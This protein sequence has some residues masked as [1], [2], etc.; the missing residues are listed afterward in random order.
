M[1]DSNP[2]E[3]TVDPHGNPISQEDG[4]PEPDPKYIG[5]YRVE[6]RLGKGGF[7][8]VFLAYDEHLERNVA[9][10]V[11]HAILISGPDDAEGYLEEAR[12]VASLDHAA[13]VPV[14]DVGSTPEC[15]FYIVSKYIEGTNLRTHLKQHRY[16]YGEAAE[17]IATVAEA[18]H[19]AHKQGLVHRD[20]KPGNILIDGQGTPHVV[21]FGLALREQNIGKG[22]KCAGTPAY[23][24]P[25][26]A[27]GE[28]HRVDGRSDIFSLGVVF[29]QLLA[30][31]KPFRGD[32]QTEILERV[33]R[34]EP[35]PLRQYDEKMPKELERICHKALAKRASERYSSAHDLAEDLRIFLA[36]DTAIPSAT[37]ASQF[38]PLESDTNSS[39]KTTS[40]TSG[41]STSQSIA[42]VSV[43][44]SEPIKVVPRGLRSF[45]AHDADFFLELL[46]GPRDRSGL[47]D[48][49]QFW[50]TRIEES[51]PDDTF[52][53]GL[54][55]G[56]SG[57]G[58]SSLVK[59]GLLPRLSE[60][61]M[62]VYIESTPAD[63][64]TRV[65]RGI[66]KACPA[67]DE[68]LNLHETM[69]AL[70]RGQGI[71][72]GR[73]VLIV[74]DQFEQWL[75][76][77]KDENYTDLVQALRQCDGGRLQCVMLVRDDFWLAVSRLLR[78]L[79]VQLVEGHNIA[80][81]D[82]FDIDHAQKVLAA[83]GR[84]FGKLP[85]EVA[86]TSKEQKEF[87][88][89][90]VAGLAQEGKVI[91]VRL[92]LFAEMMKGRPWTPAALKEM[93]GTTGVGVTF[94][95]ETFASPAASP[96]HRLHQKAARSV[97]KNLLP[98]SG[99]DIKGHMQ[100]RTDLLA[101]S[102][103]ENRPADFEELIRILDSEIRLITPTDPDG[104]DGP[105][106]GT[107]TES[108]KKYFQLAHDYLVP[109]LREWLT[110]K[111]KETMRGRAELRL[112][113]RSTLWNAKQ[114][115]RR[116]PSWWEYLNI[117]GLTRGRNWQTPERAMM[118][119]AGRYHGL[120]SVVGLAVVA[121]LMFG[122]LRLRDN[123][124]Q[125]Q[126]A[127]RQEAERK[128]RTVRAEEL[129]R[130]LQNA[131]IGRVNEIIA[132]LDPYQELAHPLLQQQFD[133][134]KDGEPQKL[135]LSL[136]LLTHD[137][138][139]VDYLSQQLLIASPEE[140]PVIRDSLA[141][142]QAELA[143]SLWAIL[144]TSGDSASGDTDQQLRAA[145]ALATWNPADTQ[146]ESFAPTAAA[147]LCAVPVSF[148]REWKEAFRPVAARL[149]EPLTGIFR[150]AKQDELSRLMA[151][152]FLADYAGKDANRLASLIS[153][154]DKKQFDVLYPI[155]SG[156]GD[157]AVS[158][159]T[160][161]IDQQIIPT[162]E[163]RPADPAWASVPDGV[164]AAIESAG[165]LLTDHYAFCLS[166]ELQKC[167]D[168]ADQLKPSGYRP[169]RFRPY[170]DG[171]ET[172]VAATW[173]RDGTNWKIHSGVTDKELLAQDTKFRQQAFSPIDVAGYVSRDSE[174]E[175]AH[176]FAAV[177]GPADDSEVRMHAGTREDVARVLYASPWASD[178]LDVVSRTAFVSDGITYRSAIWANT[179]DNKTCA[180]KIFDGY[181][182]QFSGE[183]YP[184]MVLTDISVEHPAPG[185]ERQQR[186]AQQLQVLEEAL[187]QHEDG[188]AIKKAIAAL[189]FQLQQ[190]DSALA[191][192]N[193]LLEESPDD[194]RL[195]QLR[196][197]VHARNQDEEAARIDVA[198]YKKR[199][200]DK[201][202]YV[203]LTALVDACLG[204]DIAAIEQLE[205]QIA[206]DSD[207]SVMLYHA[208]YVY[209]LLADLY[210]SKD[211]QKS[212]ECV[213]RGV[214]LMEQALDAGYTRF[215]HLRQDPDLD[216]LRTDTKFQQLLH[217]DPE[218]LIYT[219]AWNPSRNLES[220][221]L[222]GLS[223]KEHLRKSRQ[224]VLDGYRAIN[225]SA[226]ASPQDSS[227]VTASIWV[228]PRTSNAVRESLNK[229]KAQAAAAL[230]R[231]NAGS[232]AWPLMAQ[233][234]E[235][236]ARSYL[237]H[238][239]KP[240]DVKSQVIV[241][242]LEIETDNSARK[243]LLLAL[244]EFEL[245]SWPQAKQGKLIDLLQTMFTDDPEAGIRA[246]AE[247]TLRR[248]GKQE[249]LVE[250]NRKL[251]TGEIQGDRQWYVN[252]Q[253][254]TLV[255]IPGPIQFVMGSPVEEVGR[256]DGLRGTMEVMHHQRIDR[257]FA[258]MSHKVT[259][260]QYLKY[261]SDYKYD[262]K[263]ARELDA[264]ITRISWYE[265]TEYCNW[266][267][268]QEGIPED[269]WCYLPNAEDEYAE[270]MRPAPDHLQRI[271]YRLPT[272][273]EWEYA[274]SAGTRTSRYFGESEDLLGEYAWTSRHSK[275]RWMLPV[276]SLKPN[277]FGLFDMLGNAWEWGDDVC[278]FV[279]I[280]KTGAPVED[281]PNQYD[282]LDTHRRA[283]R[284]GSF[285]AQPSE[286]RTSRRFRYTP[287]F[288]N[289][290]VGMRLARTHK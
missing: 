237:I 225:V 34:Y 121:L 124:R 241:D 102:G 69:A 207:D 130:S 25:E 160:A 71:P 204:D 242:R 140:F 196:S 186:Y 247:W 127:V 228:R 43:A 45:D 240:F 176:H 167:L 98:G 182:S 60:D 80:L 267:S 139:Q 280:P 100:S 79:E 13:I 95:E 85:E 20:V 32:N 101:A 209:S 260:D 78:D 58:K 86:N 148:L 216:A 153:V 7:G 16:R 106:E 238:G 76:A 165:G 259:V 120:R 54:I 273:A 96:Q 114:E 277:D 224:L 35:R 286:A 65:L 221:E 203:Y 236:G 262:Q 252:G 210:A 21:D 108:G 193:K 218:E 282:V 189:K 74:L 113:E 217:I 99:T 194:V 198:E 250:R 222:H 27:R 162:W 137:S 118:Q 243:A 285:L 199:Y 5:R 6:K 146:W 244:G 41:P 84:A 40:S 42:L 83:F 72:V 159:L 52:S 192:L 53:V 23:M 119:K 64:E 215:E 253:E 62:S 134:A 10:K 46:P 133:S 3:I 263:Y 105:P 44:G 288:H 197:I 235:P 281:L 158:E 212:Q 33:T 274:C 111:Q 22:P 187:P 73:K 261:K 205:E 200:N 220:R 147:K 188:K 141:E 51:D 227:I 248:W 265:V 174:G 14:H 206:R 219:G 136:G 169:I 28:G 2:D 128:E 50:K 149:L 81:A 87:L 254:Q 234:P 91:C 201:D 123:I 70:R 168:I 249:E 230:L 290:S 172:K 195:L 63:T 185:M 1:T 126:E 92:A 75:H 284:G 49:L 213:H 17:L 15:P 104:F 164:S 181:K 24:S 57:C 231:M 89:R 190:D 178:G 26:Q 48:S 157:N 138:G 180:T 171:D 278:T 9:V 103:Y 67:L 175:A 156:L 107:E 155:L 152:S 94:L 173:T 112:A 66:R 233:S 245:P 31:R 93:G 29:Y 287:T 276:G 143:A 179:G 97:L 55:Y 163:D 177:W 170:A 117:V 122:G 271:G 166:M 268:E 150:D 30:G 266:L 289:Y 144:N 116:L 202:Q 145:A 36:D 151:A 68:K 4:T 269:Q 257:S 272:E 142:Y 37:A 132:Q 264:P 59:A 184:G 258:I 56:P 255:V 246:A 115:N 39:T 135:N 251:A 12:A 208:T 8:I 110:R 223:L 38:P 239:L 61:V 283:M 214:A 90:S 232:S 82:L 256:E 129:V 19:Y 211:E 109:S 226:I 270:G 18:L 47:P 229:Q 88:K 275:D 154:A 125:G 131:D 183:I 77:K 161:V 191:D 11:P 279:Y